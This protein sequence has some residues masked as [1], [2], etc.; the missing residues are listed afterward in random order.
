MS[1]TNIYTSQTSMGDNNQ[2]HC[3]SNNDGTYYYSFIPGRSSARSIT[4]SRGSSVTPGFNSKHMHTALAPLPF[5]YSKTDNG[6]WKGSA[7]T[8]TPYLSPGRTIAYK[9]DVFTGYTDWGYLYPSSSITSTDRSNALRIVSE[10]IR[11]KVKDQNANL[12]Q[13]VAE[14][15]K[16]M[17]MMGDIVGHLTGAIGHLRKGDIVG[18]AK[19]LGVSVSR[20]KRARFRKTWIRDQSEAIAS[21]WLALQYGWKPLLMDVHGLAEELARNGYQEMYTVSAA[22]TIRRPIVYSAPMINSASQSVYTGNGVISHEGMSQYT[23]RMGCTYVVRNSQAKTAAGMGLTNPA[24]LA[25]ELLPY[26]FVVDWFL[27]IGDWISSWDATVGCDFKFGYQTVFEKW[28]GVGTA[29][30][31][32]MYNPSQLMYLRRYS[33]RRQYV[34]CTRTVLSDFPSVTPPRFKNPASKEHLQN[35]IALLV[36]L[37]RGK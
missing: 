28:D 36:N 2:S 27:P 15:H 31:W 21:G 12:P 23:V 34:E 4:E 7:R 29:N 6:Y 22:K 26:S 11:S 14:G 24:L 37:F 32:Y 20:S 16:T 19:N 5:S 10:K 17:D 30:G 33:V 9:D 3:Y 25:W 18:A 35:G 8:W 13:F 1:R